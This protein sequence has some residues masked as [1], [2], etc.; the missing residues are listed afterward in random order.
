MKHSNLAIRLGHFDGIVP[1]LVFILT[2]QIPCENLWKRHFQDSNFQHVPSCPDPQELV[3][4]VRFPKPP[5]IHYQ[6]AT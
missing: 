2:K 6:P 1:S 5:A 3:P 4:L